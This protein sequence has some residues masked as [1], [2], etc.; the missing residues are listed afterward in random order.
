MQRFELATGGS[1]VVLRP[2]LQAFGWHAKTYSPDYILTQ[3]RVAQ[4]QGGVGFL[5]WNA[6]NDYSKPLEAMPEV[7]LAALH[8]LSPEPAG[9]HPASPTTGAFR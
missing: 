9:S 4:Q 8:D 6:R 2:W 3:V 7:H 1:G 5:F